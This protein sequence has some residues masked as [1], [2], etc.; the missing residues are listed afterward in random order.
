MTNALPFE[1]YKIKAV[2]KIPFSTEQERRTAAEA[3]DF[4][5]YEVSSDLV[6]I[7]LLTDSGTGA[8]ST[9]QRAAMMRADESYAGNRSISKLR[10][11]IEELLG[12]THIFPT[13]QGRAAE[14]VLISSLCKAGDIVPANT[15]FDTTRANFTSFGV[16][17]IDLP[18]PLSIDVSAPH[19]FKGNIDLA[20][21]EAFLKKEA[22]RT[23]FVLLTVTN[24][25]CADQP[26]SMRNIQ[27]TA[28]LA[29][30]YSIPLYL[31]ACRFAQNAWFIQQNEAGYQNQSIRKIVSE[32]F[33]YADGFFLSAKKDGLSP[34]GGLLGT[35]NTT[36]AQ[37]L[38]EAVLLAEGHPSYGGL[39]G[40]HLES[41]AVG[42]YE[43]TEQSYL[44][45]HCSFTRYL[46]EGLAEEGVPVVQPTGAHAV[47][48]DARGFLP[49]FSDEDQPGQA[50]VVE[51]FVRYGIRGTKMKF[52]VGSL[53]EEG[54]EFVRLALPSRTYTQSHLDY[55]IRSVRELYRNHKQVEPL[56]LVCCPK[57]LSGFSAH[58]AR[59]AQVAALETVG[60]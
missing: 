50:L 15:H 46:G 22:G 51:L 1:P 19:P 60:A 47:Y 58:Y 32:M 40:E 6:L 38:R 35:R 43:A 8:L 11:C 48:I 31:D 23:P 33:R 17:A 44:D 41:M 24:N 55:V 30:R 20:A 29:S 59:P 53:L 57:M 13:H 56:R 36:V 3:A 54:F 4:N 28:A 25:S 37:K 27:Q 16:E 49:H 5:L 34:M 9:E 18:N 7:D 10:A 52:G 26:V 2:E 21:L 39:S 14:R 45:H 42:F 12:F